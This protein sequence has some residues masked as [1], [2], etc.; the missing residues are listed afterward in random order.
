LPPRW[1]TEYSAV[2]RITFTG[3]SATGRVIARAAAANLVPVSLELGGKGANIVF[4]AA[5]LDNAVDWSVKAIFSNAGQVCLRPQR[6]GLH[7]ESLP[8]TTRPHP[9]PTRPLSDTTRPTRPLSD[10]AASSRILAREPGDA[11]GVPEHQS[12]MSRAAANDIDGASIA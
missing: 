9:I 4:D 3:E 7:R 1:L 6:H 10:P 12:V 5:A 2:D 8:D 11:R